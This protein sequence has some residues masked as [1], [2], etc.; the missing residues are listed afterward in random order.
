MTKMHSEMQDMRS[1]FKSEIKGVKS[2]ITGIK[3]ELKEVKAAV[4][5]TNFV[6]ENEIKPGIAALF[7]GYVQNSEASNRIEDELKSLRIAI[8]NLNIRTLENENNIISF[9]R[10]LVKLDKEKH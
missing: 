6:I 9:S 8:N 7:D 3:G 5:K 2:E 10:R 4:V 1:E